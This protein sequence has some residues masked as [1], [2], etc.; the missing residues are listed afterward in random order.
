MSALLFVNIYNYTILFMK[1][2]TVISFIISDFCLHCFIFL[3]NNHQTFPLSR[4]YIAAPHLDQ[5]KLQA[6]QPTS[7]YDKNLVL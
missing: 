1:Y 5:F 2:N 3:I 6:F 4:E 7:E